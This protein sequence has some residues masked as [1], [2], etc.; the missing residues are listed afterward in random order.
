TWGGDFVAALKPL[1]SEP[2]VVKHRYS[3]FVDTR[4]DLLLRSNGIRTVI[5]PGVATH[6]CVE[7]TARDAAMRDYYVVVPE[8]GVAVRGKQRP[9][10]EASLEVLGT[11]F[12]LVAPLRDIETVWAT[13]M[14]ATPRD[15][16]LKSAAKIGI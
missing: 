15:E 5:L 2:V 13:C 7:S 9:L 1:E 11:Y 10:H 3:A 6:C 12:G 16:A 4:L 14:A 8:D